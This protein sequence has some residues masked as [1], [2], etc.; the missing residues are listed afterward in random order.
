MNIASDIQNTAQWSSARDTQC[1]AGPSV[2]DHSSRSTIP[3]PQVEHSPDGQDL[4]PVV[5]ENKSQVAVEDPRRVASTR[6]RIRLQ[7]IRNTIDTSSVP[8]VTGHVEPLDSFIPL[9]R[10]NVL[11][12]TPAFLDLQRIQMRLVQPL[13]GGPFHYV[14]GVGQGPGYADNVPDSATAS[15]PIPMDERCPICLDAFKVRVETV[16]CNHSFCRAC[17][18]KWIRISWMRVSKIRAK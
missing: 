12:R 6:N 14:C 8:H 16:P 13:P 3:S 2:T 18:V 15:N 4:P 10:P 5:E 11:R 17:V 7:E 1:L 9:H